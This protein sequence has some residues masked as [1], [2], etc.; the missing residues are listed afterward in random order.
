[1][2]IRVQQ[3]SSKA[4]CSTQRGVGKKMLSAA[5]GGLA[6]MGLV[7]CTPNGGDVQ[8]DSPT[9]GN[10]A[11]IS[12]A[13][14]AGNVASQE[15]GLPNVDAT[16]YVVK[17][18]S[19]KKGRSAIRFATEDRKINCEY[20]KDRFACI[21][22]PRGQWPEEARKKGF[23]P[24]KPQTVGWWPG[25]LNGKVQTWVTQGAWP[26]VTP[27]TEVL[28]DGKSIAMQLPDGKGTRVIC[29][30]RSNTVTC[31][32]GANGFTLGD[33]GLKIL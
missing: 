2:S 1:M 8:S 15:S 25:Q 28:P 17:D 11:E 33:E 24:H 22:T 16:K 19:L 3:S 26:R 21:T 18:S 13:A 7:A 32:N 10:E 6:A 30:N 9:A 14:Q 23:E 20:Q 27:E 31:S 5:C 29:S 12:R 4:D